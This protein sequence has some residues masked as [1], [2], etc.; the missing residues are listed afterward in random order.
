M[1]S[2]VFDS[3]ISS[4]IHESYAV[5]NILTFTRTL[6]SKVSPDL[7]DI[8]I[9]FNLECDYFPRCICHFSEGKIET[10]IEGNIFLRSLK[11]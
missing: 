9:Q 5:R 2:G 4:M 3:I 10:L 11:F 7:F 8:I 6:E 1:T